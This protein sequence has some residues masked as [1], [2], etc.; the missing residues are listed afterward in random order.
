MTVLS[1]LSNSTCGIQNELVGT[2]EVEE[3]KDLVW[4][5]WIT[6]RAQDAQDIFN[7]PR[8]LA[9]RAGIVSIGQ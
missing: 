9:R 4:T 6:M 7:T 5:E 1:S 3:F 8:G 2:K